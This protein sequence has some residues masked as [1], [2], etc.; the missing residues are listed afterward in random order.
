MSYKPQ[1]LDI[2]LQRFCSIL[3]DL[4]GFFSAR[5]YHY[6]VFVYS[7]QNSLFLSRKCTFTKI[8][9]ESVG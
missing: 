8:V 7:A 2:L 9:F 1:L 4:S 3:D 6:R 5:M